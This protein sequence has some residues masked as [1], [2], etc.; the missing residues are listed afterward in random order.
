[1][2]G[3]VSYVAL[4]RTCEISIRKV[5]GATQQNVIQVLAADFLKLLAVSAVLAVGFGIWFSN[6]WLQDFSNKTEPSLWPYFI[7]ISLVFLLAIL[8]IAYRS[9][10]VYSLNPAKTLKTD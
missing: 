8:T 7:S 2:F 9:W 10:K 3:L 5:L 1:L 4:R 6:Q